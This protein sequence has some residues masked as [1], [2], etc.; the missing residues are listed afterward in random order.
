MPDRNIHR[1]FKHNTLQIPIFLVVAVVFAWFGIQ[2]LRGNTCPHAPW[3][4][5]I[6][7]T[8]ALLI[9]ALILIGIVFSYNTDLSLSA[10]PES[11]CVTSRWLNLY[12]SHEFARNQIRSFS[13]IPTVSE[14]VPSTESYY[15]VMDIWMDES[16]MISPAL[17][18][19]D[20]MK[21]A[22]SLADMYEVSLNDHTSEV[23]LNDFHSCNAASIHTKRFFEKLLRKK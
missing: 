22:Q 6:F 17:K 8:P 5:Y 1:T 12:D 23:V 21:F 10:C 16:F 11:L 14:G 4:S 18:K 13:I 19:S 9:S 20:A 7:Y 3:L 15:L 2:G